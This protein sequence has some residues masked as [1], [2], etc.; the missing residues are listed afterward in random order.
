MDNKE[1]EKS[2]SMWL[3]IGCMLIISI[4][5]VM[6]SHHNEKNKQSVSSEQIQEVSDKE[7]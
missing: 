5:Q 3:I 2:N 7:Q 1:E 6:Y 4:S